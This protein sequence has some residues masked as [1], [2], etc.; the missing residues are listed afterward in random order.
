MSNL[1]HI[2]PPY[3]R[4]SISRDDSTET[5]PADTPC[6]RA[7]IGRVPVSAPLH[8]AI[9]HQLGD[10]RWTGH[11]KQAEWGVDDLTVPIGV[12]RPEQKDQLDSSRNTLIISREG[13]STIVGGVP[14]VVI[15]WDM[16]GLFLEP[17]HDAEGDGVPDEEDMQVEEERKKGPRIRAG[18]TVQD[19]LALIAML[20]QAIDQI[21]PPDTLQQLTDAAVPGGLGKHERRF[22]LVT[23]LAVDSRAWLSERWGRGIHC[24]KLQRW[25]RG[26][27]KKS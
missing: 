6:S 14:D 23:G 2:L 25:M 1:A 21:T 22:K 16:F 9:A 19:Y 11:G 4:P 12:V 26:T 5:S 24:W 8:L 27:A 18:C 3:S 15:A 13:A 20:R 7:L 10:Q 17:E